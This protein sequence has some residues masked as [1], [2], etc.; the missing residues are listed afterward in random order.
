MIIID[1][2]LTQRYIIDAI[3]SLD[4][5]CVPVAIIMC[6]YLIFESSLAHKW[7]GIDF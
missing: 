6:Q 5:K 4:S 2:M 7:A 3:Y 1:F